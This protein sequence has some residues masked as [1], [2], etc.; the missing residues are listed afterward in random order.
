MPDVRLGERICAYVQP[1]PGE[2]ITFEALISFLKEK[3]AS[4]ML[5]PERLEILEEFPLTPMQK[6]DKQALRRD[7]AQKLKMEQE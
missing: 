6:I 1:R 4:K 3:G 7:V 5:L 2:E